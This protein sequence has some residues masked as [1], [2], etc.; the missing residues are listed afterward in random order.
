MVQYICPRCNYTT[1]QRSDI[2]KHFKRKRPCIIVNEDI[3]LDECYKKILG[4]VTKNE[5]KMNPK[6]QKVTKNESKM[7]PNESKMNPW[8]KKVTKN[9]SKMNPNGF[10][11][12]FLNSCSLRKENKKVVNGKTDNTRLLLIK[13]YKCP[14][15]KK[16]YFQTSNLHKHMKNCD[17][18]DSRTY[19]KRK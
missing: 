11:Y 2:R 9:E 3:S 14:K 4:V 10:T 6:S 12:D 16:V 15:C 13:K 19:S 7:N 8:G 18:E 17:K 5:S 1:K